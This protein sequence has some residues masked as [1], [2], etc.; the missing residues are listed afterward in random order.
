MLP[1]NNP[2]SYEFDTNC[3]RIDDLVKE[4]NTNIEAFNCG[5]Y[6]VKQVIKKLND[7]FG[8]GF[9]VILTYDD[10]YCLLH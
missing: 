3:F 5:L 6:L 4:K 7:L 2:M 1:P 10:K 9:E 8:S